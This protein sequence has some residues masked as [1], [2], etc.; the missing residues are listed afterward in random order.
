LPYVPMWNVDDE[1]WVGNITIGN[2]G[3]VFRV[4]FDTG[5]SNLWIPSIQC[6]DKDGGCGG[7]LYYDHDASSTYHPDTCEILFIP[8]GTGFVGGYLSN[9]TVNVGGIE[10]EA[11]FGE[12]V[13]MADFFADVPLD[14]ILGLAFEDIAMDG[15]TP[16][17]DLMMEGKLLEKNVFSVFLSN[18]AGDESS[19]IIFGGVDQKYYS[20]DFLYSTVYIPSYWLIGTESFYVNGQI[21]YKCLAGYCPTVVDTGTSIIIG[22]PYMLDPLINAIGPVAPDCSNLHSLPT[23]AFEINGNQFTL[24][25]D[26]Y[27]I[28]DGG[29][30]ELAIESSYLITPFL[31]LG[32]PFLRAYYTVFDRDQS[33]VGFAVAKHPNGYY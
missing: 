19:V 22:P 1:L 8:Y 15:V 18:I 16:I 27:V 10:V 11:M 6:V 26:Y 3:Q 29:Q 14:G 9:D 31:I 13:Y 2:P 5:S 12:A 30:C 25:P 32:D 24:T 4:V 28:K 17:F 7:K 20:G 23:I 21:I 33:R